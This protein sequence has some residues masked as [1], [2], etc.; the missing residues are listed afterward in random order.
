[1]KALVIERFGAPADVLAVA[2]RPDPVP[3]PGQARIRMLQSPIHNHDLAI[4]RGVYG[5]KP[6]LPAI[7][8]TEAVGVVDQVGP[9]TGPLQVGQR[10]CAA[11]VTGAWAEFFLARSASVVPVPATV[12]DD[13][14]CQ[15]L[16]MPLSALMLIEDLDLK[17]GD[18]LIQNAA[19]GAVGRLVEALAKDR[20]VNVI[21]LV[22]RRETVTELK[23]EGV[24]HALAS[25]DAGW[26]A[27]VSA[28]TGGAPVT[29]AV[30][31]VGGKAANDLLNVMAPGGLLMSFGAMSGQALT[32][33]VAN[34]VF[35]Q[36]TV[37]G[38]WGTKRSESTPREE[39]TRMIGQL[40]RLAATDKLPLRIAAKFALDQ[41]TQAVASS[42]TPRNGKIAFHT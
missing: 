35:K 12:S 11:G 13:V 6:A 18:W 16:A 21:N 42:E 5:V 9:D 19:N 24:R 17:A 40:L 4:I 14:A 1:M 2:Q 33:D 36:T 10:I 26:A 29:R 39:M 8:G 20:G 23:A 37:K 3:G 22:R 41:P 28:L 15:L 38:F 31:S 32:I 34:V 30:D 25:D 7:P 27:Q